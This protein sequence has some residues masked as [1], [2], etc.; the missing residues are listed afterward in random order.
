MAQAGAAAGKEKSRLRMGDRWRK[1]WLWQRSRTMSFWLALLLFPAG[2]FLARASILEDLYPFAAAF[3][4]AV[5]VNRRR[6]APLFLLP[7]LL[8]TWQVVPREQ[9]GIYALAQLLLLFILYFYRSERRE[10]LLLP[11]SVLAVSAVSKGVYL[12]LHGFSDYQL[13]LMLLESLFSAGLTVIMLQLAAALRELSSRRSF[14][15]NEMVCL[16]VCLMGIVSGIG[17]FQLGPVDLQIAVSAFLVMLAACWGGAGTGA[18]AGALVGVIPSLAVSSGP[19]MIGIYAFSGLLSGAF[20]S[21]GRFGAALGFLLGNQLLALY[22]ISSE[23]VQLIV[24]ASLAAAL[25]L[26]LLPAKPMRKLR[27]LFL[28]VPPAAVT[29]TASERQLRISVRRLKN[30]VWLFR[31]LA[32]KC[33][34]ISGSALPAGDDE[35]EMNEVLA[36]LSARVCSACSMKNICWGIDR[37]N[38]DKSVR[39]IFSVIREKG[40]VSAR[41]LPESF[42]RRCTHSKELLAVSSCLYDLYCRSSY[43]RQQQE[44]ARQLL[45]RQLSGSASIL[46]RTARELSESSRERDLLERELAKSLRNAGLPVESAGVLRMNGRSMELVADLRDCV[47]EARCLPLLEDQVSA[48]LGQRCRVHEYSCAAGCGGRCRYRLLQGGALRMRVGKAQAARESGAVCGDSGESALLEDGRALLAISD[49]MGAGMRASFESGAAVSLLTRLLETGFARADAIDTVNSV[50]AM[51]REEE[52]FVTLDLCLVDLYGG[53]AEFI[54]TGA[55][56]SFIKRGNEVLMLRAESLPL[57]IWN[58]VQ[59]EVLTERICPGD[60]IVLASDGLID[61]VKDAEWVRGVL[62]GAQTEEAQELAE[63]LLE[64]AEHIAGGRLR[65]DIT[66]MVGRIEA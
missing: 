44:G 5:T 24:F 11:L 28:S 46:E 22:L 8:G 29:E 38:T 49:G 45:M 3:V 30:A 27:K 60:M 43:W 35:A 48:L 63:L 42:A 33:G 12:G 61:S 41:E 9:F 23:E 53:K 40:G 62:V 37:E 64:R 17:S 6:M 16:F 2:F 14:A 34:R 55:A 57:G 18:A 13:V 20:N 19:A 50:L 39:E 51:R 15:A 10:R 26:L 47:G 32:E 36:E 4:A 66:V 54:K 7:V 1:L 31:D 65:D 56:P 25:F 59:K 52:S 58:S 21:F